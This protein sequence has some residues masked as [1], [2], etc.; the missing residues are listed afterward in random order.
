MTDNA[1]IKIG[2]VHLESDANM[3]K[4]VIL[5][6]GAEEDRYFLMFVGNAEFAAIAKEKGMVDSPRPITH[7]FYLKI[8]GMLAV[9]FLRVEIY[10]VRNETYY[11]NV[12]IRINDQEHAV[13]SRPSDAV[14]LALNR[15]IPILVSSGLFNRR[16]T[17]KEIK[18][19]ESIIKRVNF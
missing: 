3:G 16:L 8:L 15:G 2:W 14:A 10:A 4:M 1:M 5:K 9:E 13:D 11:A 17:Q 18:E 19:Y 12:V 7:E 6:E